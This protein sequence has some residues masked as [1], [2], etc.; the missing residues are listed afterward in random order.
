MKGKNKGRKLGP[1]K[2]EHIAK[3][4]ETRKANKEKR[5][6]LLT[7][8]IKE[9]QQLLIKE[10]ISKIKSKGAKS[11]WVRRKANG[12][13]KQKPE[14]IARRVA[15]MVANKELIRQEKAMMIF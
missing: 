15:T 5:D 3:C 9:K 11:M 14:T 12:T 10:E 1:Q 6:A 8:K 4:V 7:P 13:D 2:P